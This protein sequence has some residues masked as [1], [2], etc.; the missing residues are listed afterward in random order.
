MVT[1]LFQENSDGLNDATVETSNG[2]LSCSFVHDIKVTYD[3][4]FPLGDATI[5]LDANKYHLLLATGPLDGSGKIARHEIKRASETAF[6][7]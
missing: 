5:D 1:F 4:P 7:L 6:Q 2:V 3:L